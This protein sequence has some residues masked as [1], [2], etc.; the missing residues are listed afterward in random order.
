MPYVYSKNSAH[1]DFCFY[2][3]GPGGISE[4]TKKITIK[5]RA[6]VANNDPHKGIFT[7]DGVVNKVTDEELK[8]LKEHPIFKQQVAAGFIKVETK[9]APV[10]KV[11]K[12]MKDKDRSA[13][14]TPG[15]FKKGD[16]VTPMSR[17]A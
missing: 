1:V 11:A 10:E 17:A 15:D 13:P 7:P 16:A 8:A 5:G 12:D 9:Q 4:I 3:K 2:T 14:V 6:N